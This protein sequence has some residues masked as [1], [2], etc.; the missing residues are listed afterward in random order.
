MYLEWGQAG[1]AANRFEQALLIACEAGDHAGEAVVLS[2][3]ADMLLNFGE[4]TKA[5]GYYER[6]LPYV[7]EMN[8]TASRLFVLNRLGM[9]SYFLHDAAKAISYYEQTLMIARD[10]HSRENEAIALFNVGD[11][12]HLLGKFSDA[13]PYYKEALAFDNQYINYKCEIGLGISYLFLNQAKE[14]QNHF[15]KAIK[16]HQEM[17]QKDPRYSPWRPSLGLS[18]LGIGKTQDGLNAYSHW[19]ELSPSKEHVHYSIQDLQVLKQAPQ[20]IAGLD[21]AINLL[22]S[23]MSADHDF[24]V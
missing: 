19:L 8:D 10:M 21:E 3:Y 18:L 5:I 12:Y 23:A 14:A 6:A 24:N 11:A 13:I 7:E 1:E 20:D 17:H 2:G 16:I 15:E 22:E 4:A 9:A